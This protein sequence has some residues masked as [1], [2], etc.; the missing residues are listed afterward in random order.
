M[1]DITHQISSAE[2]QIGS[3]TLEA[4]RARTL[5]ISRVYDTP[6]EDLWDACTVLTDS[7]AG[8]F[9]FRATCGRA[10]ATSFRTT[11]AGRSSVASRPRSWTRPGSTAVRPHGSSCA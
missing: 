2:R 9:R 1:I 8:S 7:H 6:P 10:A 4:S 11:R 3:R 5:M